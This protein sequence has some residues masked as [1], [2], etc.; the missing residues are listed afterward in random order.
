MTAPPFPYFGGKQILATRIAAAFPPHGHYV[1]PFAG[2]LAVLLAKPPS[3]FETVN[4]LDSDLITFW[5]VLRDQPDDLTRVCALTPHSRG[6]FEAARDRP[7]DLTDIER[8]RRVW[9]YLTQGRGGIL[10]NTGWRH[11][12]KPSGTTSVPAYLR[13]YVARIHPA[14]ERLQ[15]VS[16]ECRPA[17]EVITEYGQHPDV[18]LY[19]DPPY[20]GSTRGWGANYQIEMRGADEHL[21]VLDALTVCRAAVVLSGYSSALYDAHLSGWSRVEF[22]T[23]TGQST[24][25]EWQNRTEV[26]WSN[27]PIAGPTGLFELGG[28]S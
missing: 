21:E 15:R 1:E 7:H 17:L 24:R 12:K 25:G 6:E 14:L 27:R 5:R 13:G 2:S 9:V 19:V 4:D 28:A 23:G 26:L 16:L 10:R 8:A 20:L 18:L 11:Y 3:P 22:A